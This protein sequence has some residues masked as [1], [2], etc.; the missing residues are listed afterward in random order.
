MPSICVL[1][2][3]VHLFVR[4]IKLTC[5]PPCCVSISVPWDLFPNC[6]RSGWFS[7]G[8]WNTI[9]PV[10][11]WVCTSHSLI[12]PHRCPNSCA[13]QFKNNK[14][15]KDLFRFRARNGFG[16][17]QIISWLETELI[18]QLQPDLNYL[19]ISVAGQVQVEPKIL[20]Q[21]RVPDW[22]NPTP[23]DPYVLTPYC[24]R[25]SDW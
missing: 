12:S 15:L 3:D 11:R 17:T 4:C 20:V 23:S 13:M 9:L 10:H 16:L 25:W 2:V 5:R 24:S 6:D 22:P 7:N 21:I 19:K 18:F 8:T 14:K 1:S